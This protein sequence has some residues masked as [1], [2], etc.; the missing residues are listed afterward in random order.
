MSDTVANNIDDSA[1]FDA[2]ASFES[3]ND[4]TLYWTLSLYIDAAKISSHLPTGV[5]GKTVTKLFRKAQLQ[6]YPSFAL[7]NAIDPLFN[8]IAD[9]ERLGQAQDFLLAAGLKGWQ[10]RS[11]ATNPL[12][13]AAGAV[14][15]SK[16]TLRFMLPKEFSWTTEGEIFT[17]R[18]ATTD[19]DPTLVR[20]VSLRRFWFAHSD[21]ALS[22]HLSFTYHY[23]AEHGPETYYFLSLLQKLAVP[24]EFSLSST[25]LQELID[26]TDSLSTDP[27]TFSVFDANLGIDPLDKITVVDTADNT[28]QSPERFWPFIRTKF[29]QDAEILFTEVL[30]KSYDAKLANLLDTTLVD[31]IEVPGLRIPRNRSLFHIQ[32]ER[33]F[34][35]LLPVA[36]DTGLP[37]P[38]KSMVQEL[39]YKPY[40]RR[41]D[42]ERKYSRPVIIGEG[43]KFLNWQW[44]KNR[45]DYQ[46]ALANG[47]FCADEQGVHTITDPA[48]FETAMHTG[49]CWQMKDVG[50]DD[51]VHK[52]ARP[53]RH[54][55]PSYEAGRTDCIDYL[56]LAGFNQNIIDWLNQDTSEILDSTDPIYPVDDSQLEEAFFVR[57]ANHRALITYVARSRSLEVGNDYIGTC[58]YAFLI[59]ILAMHNEFLA[60]SHEDRAASQIDKINGDLNSPSPDFA[61]IEA[62]IN[63]LK[64]ANYEVFE[65]HRYLNV[66]RYDTERD[67]FEKLEQLRGIDRRNAALL[68]AIQSLEDKSSDLES[69][70]NAAQQALEEK[71]NK[72]LTYVGIAIGWVSAVG[73]LFNASQYSK[74]NPLG[75]VEDLG[76]DRT[77]VAAFLGMTAWTLGLAGFLGL[78]GVLVYEVIRFCKNLGKA[79]QD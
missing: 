51:N 54:Y 3:A 18:L 33:F 19:Q 63:S 75:Y 17:C 24:K 62:Q 16:S 28:A 38:R 13:E 31:V 70:R 25:R 6:H 23:G 34:K 78:A 4:G 71:R 12:D 67:V 49:E 74:D 22:Y 61:D 35:R 69:R 65:T 32:D 40:Q 39:C 53:V 14:R 60:R 43:A 15:E 1:A 42:S 30:N 77:E 37:V 45:E 5:T 8:D 44:L 73:V 64:T 59:H 41:F 68:E 72:T 36:R 10:T 66:F 57:Y 58:P 27:Y 50:K 47:W 55:A 46:Y 21:G 79:K 11:S 20:E 76:L 9:R 48:D 52:L 29:E 26:K 56:F 7:R 2:D